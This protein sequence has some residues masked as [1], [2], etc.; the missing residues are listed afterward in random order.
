M[1]QRNENI[2][3]DENDGYN[4]ETCETILD[5]AKVIYNEEGERFKQAEAKTNIALAFVGILFA[6][7]L[8]YL[9]A[10]KPSNQEI[11]YLI[12]T[13]IFQLA[14]F[15]LFT[16]SIVYFLY[17][18]KTGKYEQVALEN[19]VNENFA[20]EKAEKA[21]LLLAATYKD[22]IDSNKNNLESKLK[23][24]S[25]GLNLMLF[26]FLVLSFHF[27]IEEVIRYVK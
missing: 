27:I 23:L 1:D 25:V 26:G 17:S 5:T 20:R 8:T 12:Y 4:S 7:Y 9:G 3:Q 10:F 18:I 21:K 13:F 24:Y 6:A 14:I 15:I 22:A 11:S 2:P 19:I 16:L